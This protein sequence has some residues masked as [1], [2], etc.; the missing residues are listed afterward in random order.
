MITIFI[1]QIFTFIV[2]LSLLIFIVIPFAGRLMRNEQ[3]KNKG[4]NTFG[5]VTNSYPTGFSLNGIPQLEVTLSY[6]INGVNYEGCATL[7]TERIFYLG[8]VVPIRVNP[9]NLI[10]C[11]IVITKI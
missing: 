7:F 3:F 11:S 8:V 1:R 4:I 5:T 10:D 2:L 6:T 9:E